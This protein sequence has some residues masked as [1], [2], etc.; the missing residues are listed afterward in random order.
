V[1]TR[2]LIGGGLLVLS[3]LT[4]LLM[5]L[6]L[7]RRIHKVE[8]LAV[9]V[10]EDLKAAEELLAEVDERG[11]KTSRLVSDQKLT[12]RLMPYVT[13]TPGTTPSTG[14]HAKPEPLLP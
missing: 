10:H 3:L 6:L 1:P 14:K 2:E 8:D 9:A 11:R 7:V 4:L 5:I 12:T 13:Q